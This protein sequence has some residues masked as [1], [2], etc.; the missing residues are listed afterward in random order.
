[1]DTSAERSVEFKESYDNA[2]GRTV[3]S[4]YFGLLSSSSQEE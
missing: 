1:L 2:D 3:L 4:S